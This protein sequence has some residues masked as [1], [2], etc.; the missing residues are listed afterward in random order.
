MRSAAQIMSYELPASMALL[1]VVLLAGS[2][3]TEAI[4]RG[5][6]GFP[7][8]WNLFHGP[9]T[10]V[11]FVIYFVS[12]LA[13]GNRIPFDLPEAESEL[14]SGYN[15]EYSG[16]RFS[17]YFLTEWTNLLVIGCVVTALFL[18]GWQIPGVSAD[19]V[20]QSLVL[21][22]LGAALFLAKA[23]SLVFVI[24]WIRWT[25]PRLRVDQMMNLC[26]KFFIPISLVSFL[27]LAAWLWLVPPLV[28]RLLQGALFVLVGLG[29]TAYFARR[30]RYN[31]RTV[32]ADLPPGGEP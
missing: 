13:E 29:G 14:V 6:G 3:S 9:W 1:T 12:A 8:Q 16:F 20:G 5:Q 30:V 11:A 2:L 7:W 31:L 10:L 23:S 15:T 21:Q 27:V 17:I 18:G 19:A 22:L 32:G 26:W 25:L 24:I 28:Q 4:V